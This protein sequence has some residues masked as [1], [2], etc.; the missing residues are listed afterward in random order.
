MA[1][2][3]SVKPW[4]ETGDYPTQAQFYQAFDWLRWKDELLAITNITGLQTILNS[5]ATLANVKSLYIDQITLNADGTYAM[6]K[7]TIITGIIVD[8]ASDFT[9]NIGKTPGGVEIGDAL[10]IGGSDPEAI[11]L[12]IEAIRNARTIYFGGITQTTKIIIIK[13]TI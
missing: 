11:T 6:P 9:L 5:V 10:E 1:Y 7:G 4:F 8:V 2:K 3:D 13:N 12:M